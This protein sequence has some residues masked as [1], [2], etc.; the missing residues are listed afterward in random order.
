MFLQITNKFLQIQKIFIIVVSDF[1]S[2][3]L[4]NFLIASFM[5]VHIA[6]L[7]WFELNFA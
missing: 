1:H 3:S 4:L 5:I 6:Y 7:F 2:S